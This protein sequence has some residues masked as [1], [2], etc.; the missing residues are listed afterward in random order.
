MP[1]RNPP[2]LEQARFVYDLASYGT[3]KYKR[4]TYDNVSSDAFVVSSGTEIQ[5][6][7]HSFDTTARFSIEDFP[8]IVTEDPT[9]N[10]LHEGTDTD[11]D[12]LYQTYAQLD[13]IVDRID[14]NFAIGMEVLTYTAGNFAINGVTITLTSYRAQNQVPWRQSYRVPSTL[15]NMTTLGDNQILIVSDTFGHSFP[16]YAGGMLEIQISVDG[17]TGTGTYRKGILSTFPYQA[18]GGPREYGISGFYMYMRPMPEQLDSL[19]A[20]GWSDAGKPTQPIERS[21]HPRGQF[22]GLNG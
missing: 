17:T 9:I 6:R 4:L 16:L 8:T 13:S 21:I 20:G 5:R 19:T 3:P 14:F 18:T 11:F 7:S 12:R 22:G 1:Q 2:F 15:A 10:L